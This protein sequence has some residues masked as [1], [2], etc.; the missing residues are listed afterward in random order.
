[1]SYLDELNAERRLVILQLMIAEGGKSNDGSLLTA[2]REMGL[3]KALDQQACRQLLRELAERDCATT[4]MFR[5]T[6][7]VAT[8]TERGRMAVAGDVSIDGIK[9]PHRGL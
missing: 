5:D 7:M 8:V 6:V 9:S 3:G 2:L 1:M 4:T